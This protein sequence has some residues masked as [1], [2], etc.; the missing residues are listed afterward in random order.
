MLLAAPI[1]QRR[2]L[3]FVEEVD[4]AAPM[5]PAPPQAAER[6]AAPPAAAAGGRQAAGVRQSAER[7]RGG[8][9]ASYLEPKGHAFKGKK[10]LGDGG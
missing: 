4:P 3:A 5:A 10:E 8:R 7:P 6:T 1:V 2:M 9:A